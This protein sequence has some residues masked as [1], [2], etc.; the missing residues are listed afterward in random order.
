VGHD[1]DTNR[2]TV[3]PYRTRLTGW[4]LASVC[5]LGAGGQISAWLRAWSLREMDQ[6]LEALIVESGMYLWWVAFVLWLAVLWFVLRLRSITIVFSGTGLEFMDF[7]GNRTVVPYSEVRGVVAAGKPLGTDSP[8]PRGGS[9]HLLRGGRGGDA[10]SLRMPF[11]RLA[12]RNQ[13]EVVV[14]RVLDVLPAGDG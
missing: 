6:G 12:D 3:K 14:R 1:R 13:L 5:A 10:R 7:R 4:L 11:V 2:C 8:V 9:L